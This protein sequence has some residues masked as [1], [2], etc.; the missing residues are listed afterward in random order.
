MKR[1]TVER[2][3][4]RRYLIGK[5]RFS[6]INIIS[7]LATLGIAFGVAALI[8]VMSVFNGFNSLVL[9]IL[10]DVDPHIK[11]ERVP[12][13]AGKSASEVRRMLESNAHDAEWSP[14]IERKA[15]AVAGGYNNFV[16][17]KG[18]DPERVDKVS[19]IRRK[20]T[21]GRADASDEY[22]VFLGLTL[23][24]RLHVMIGDTLTLISPAGMEAMLTQI[25]TPTVFRCPV[26][27]LFDSKNKVYDQTYVFMRLP[28]ANAFFRENETGSGFELRFDD[29][30]RSDAE[31]DT[32]AALIGEGW[33]VLT[34]YDLHKDLYSVMKIERWSAFVLLAVIIAVAVFNILASLTMLVLEKKRDIGILRAIGMPSRRIQR[35]FLLQGMWIAIA[36]VA[37]GLVVG[38]IPT[39]LQ[40]QFGLVRLDAAFIIPALP[41]EIRVTDLVLIIVSTFTLCLAAA[42][43][44]ARQ[45]RRVEIIDAVRW[46]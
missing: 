45:A 8:V 25:V 42:W 18:Y 23:A 1:M 21:L 14:F 30:S 39:W 35:I 24:D 41:V 32:L 7:V 3:I 13:A 38:L 16:W 9:S 28:T 27:G 15:M 33:N 6:F 5:K 37:S 26:V 11:I 4:A 22:G 20:I 10:Q 40:H 36:G 43:L 12:G 44:P 19:G 29:I 2:F 17:V 34:W 31:R 46:E